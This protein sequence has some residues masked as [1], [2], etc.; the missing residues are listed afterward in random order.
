MRADFKKNDF[1]AYEVREEFL[2][3]LPPV[4][5]TVFFAC[6]VSLNVWSRVL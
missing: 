3:Q 6:G 1:N 2:T 5:A 4:N